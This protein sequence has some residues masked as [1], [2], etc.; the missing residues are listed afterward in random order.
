MQN[1]RNC[2]KVIP[3]SIED[4]KRLFGR[5][6]A[7]N[8]SFHTHAPETPNTKRF[9]LHDLN[10][11]PVEEIQEDLQKY[12]LTPTQITTIPIKYPRF[13]DQATYIVHFDKADNVTLNIIKQAKYIRSTVARWT[14]Y[15]P[16]GD[17]VNICSRCT[18]PGHTVTNCN[19]TP[20]CKVCSGSHLTN[21]CPLILAKRQQNKTEIDKIHLKCPHCGEQ[22]HCW[23]SS[24]FWSCSLHQKQSSPPAK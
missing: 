3:N 21:D 1:L 18:I 15:I 4:H 7:Q 14:H 17:G 23:L 9:V 5:L 12:G 10:S 2:V 22:T 16:N 6:K 19:R 13:A 24:L 8:L 11:H 20:K